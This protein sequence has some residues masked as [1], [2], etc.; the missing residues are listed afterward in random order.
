MS[1]PIAQRAAAIAT[2]LQA[3]AD[4]VPIYFGFSDP[5]T[6][7]DL[8]ALEAAVDGL[9]NTLTRGDNGLAF[10]LGLTHPELGCIP[11]PAEVL[12]AELA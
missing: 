9:V 4:I 1:D 8:L 7:Q 6:D 11:T 2:K 5:S 12:A 3:I 10:E